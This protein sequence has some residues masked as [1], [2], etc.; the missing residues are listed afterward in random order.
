LPQV[1]T[2]IFFPIRKTLPPASCPEKLPTPLPSTKT[3]PTYPIVISTKQP[4]RNILKTKK[5]IM[6]CLLL[7]RGVA[8]KNGI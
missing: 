1:K 6:A 4:Q 8:H 2:G 5:S 3:A 7:Q